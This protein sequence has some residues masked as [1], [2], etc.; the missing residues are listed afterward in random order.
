MSKLNLLPWREEQRSKTKKMFMLS[1]LGA[2]ALGALCIA[3][4]YFWIDNNIQLQKERVAY[5]K[6]E[7][8]VLDRDIK[9]IKE[10]EVTRKALS[11]RIGIIDRLQSTRPSIVHLFDEMVK[12]LPNGLYLTRLIQQ[13]NKIT[14]QGKSESNAR[15]SSYMERLNI[16]PWL[17]SSNLDII[18][19]D[20]K[21][22]GDLRLRNFKLDVT[23]LL[24]PV[25]KRGGGNG[26]TRTE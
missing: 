11:D 17:S 13:G 14:L 23:Q 5:L 26:S 4:W 6:Q 7:I 25:N 9:E 2:V 22:T 16:S 18:S 19:I 21:N 1:A 8:R 20:K 10:L 12:S 24:K 3:G 15:V